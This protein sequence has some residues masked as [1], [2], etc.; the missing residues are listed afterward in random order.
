MN[1]ANKAP[2]NPAPPTLA[3]NPPTNPTT[4]AGRSAILTA[5]NPAKTGNKNPNA[6]SPIVLKKAANGVFDPKFAGFNSRL[7]NKNARAI[8]IPPATTKGSIFETPFIK[9]LYNW[10]PKLSVDSS[11]TS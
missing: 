4:M 1:P 11:T 10:R 2:K 6:A 9:C 5:I 8:K 3:N 7:S